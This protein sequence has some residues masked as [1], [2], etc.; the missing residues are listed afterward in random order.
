MQHSTTASAN[1]TDLSSILRCT[2]NLMEPVTDAEV[3]AFGAH[4]RVDMTLSP[5]DAFA[6]VLEQLESLGLAERN[7]AAQ[8]AIRAPFPFDIASAQ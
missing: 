2:A 5:Q 7:D 3:A 8:W 6:F 4:I 1:R